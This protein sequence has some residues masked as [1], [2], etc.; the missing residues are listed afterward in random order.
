MPWNVGWDPQEDL[1][2]GRQEGRHREEA[3]RK[4]LALP[5]NVYLEGQEDV[6]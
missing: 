5:W 6:Q 3:P 4:E 1:L 2:E